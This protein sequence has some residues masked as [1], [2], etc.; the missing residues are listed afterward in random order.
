MTNG[1]LSG[2]RVL[3]FS[4]ALAGPYA[5]MVLADLGAEVLKVEHPAGGDRT[6]RFTDGDEN[7]SPYFGSINRNKKSILLDVKQP[8]GRDLALRLAAQADVVVHNMGPG[9]AE[10]LGLSYEQL[11]EGNPRLIYAIVTGFGRE[12][13]WANKTGVDPVIQA[14]SGAMSFTGEPDGAPVRIGFSTVD[15][16]G[17]MWLAMGVLAALN[18]RHASGKGQLL[19]V[20]LLEAQMAWMENAMVRFMD[21]GVAPR[22]LG[23]THTY[24]KLTRAYQTRN[25]WIVAGLTARNWK[26]ACLLWGRN[27]WAQDEE[28]DRNLM[29]HD[30][31]LV[32]QIQAILREQDTEYWIEKLESIRVSCT[33]VNTMKEAVELPPLKERGFI[34]ETTD[35]NGRKLRIAGSPLHMSR[36]PG[37]VR[38]AAPVLGEHAREA[39]GSWLGMGDEEFARYEAEGI[40]NESDRTLRS[41]W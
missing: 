38:A 19:D 9:V 24:E 7:F 5:T 39:L 17:G 11:S 2:V 35:R 31:E 8:G 10:R 41:F 29:A 26:D 4:H 20:S 15:V 36:T 22:P 18:E 27:D 37:T 3:D 14:L 32:P 23:S 40:F 33:P 12:G 1:A 28:L 21:T 30:K 16:A 6:R 34:C 13:S 25:G